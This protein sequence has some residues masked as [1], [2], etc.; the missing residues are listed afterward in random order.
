MEDVGI[1]LLIQKG[2]FLEGIYDLGEKVRPFLDLWVSVTVSGGC[3]WGW[4]SGHA[5]VCYL[6]MREWYG[7]AG[8]DRRLA[9][10]MFR[11]LA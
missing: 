9:F 10:G 2:T 3:W 11:V 1:Q 4:P 5:G 7:A 6:A 8:D